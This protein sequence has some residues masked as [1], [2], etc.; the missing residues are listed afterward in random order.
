MTSAAVGNAVTHGEARVGFRSAMRAI[1]EQVPISGYAAALTTYGPDGPPQE[2]YFVCCRCGEK[3]NVLKP[4][5]A[6]AGGPQTRRKVN[7][8][9]V[10]DVEG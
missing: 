8:E 10:S 3:G 4:C 7:T 9:G 5:M 1:R 2:Q 6:V